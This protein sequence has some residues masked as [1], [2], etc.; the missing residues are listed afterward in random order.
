LAD[1][2]SPSLCKHGA[3]KTIPGGEGYPPDKMCRSKSL[4]GPVAAPLEVEALIAQAGIAVVAQVSTAVEASDEPVAEAM[5]AP[6]A[7][8][9]SW[10]EAQA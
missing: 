4:T 8:A 5:A 10:A 1:H 9:S 7:E 6:P 2:R 3:Y